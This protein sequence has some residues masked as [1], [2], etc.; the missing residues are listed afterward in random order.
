MQQCTWSISKG[1]YTWDTAFKAYHARLQYWCGLTYSHKSLYWSLSLSLSL[2]LSDYTPSTN[3]TLS[4]THTR[5]CTQS[6]CH[7]H[8]CTHTHIHLHTQTGSMHPVSWSTKSITAAYS[9]KEVIIRWQRSCLHHQFATIMDRQTF[10][11]IPQGSTRATLHMLSIASTI[12]RP[13]PLYWQIYIAAYTVSMCTS[14]CSG[15]TDDGMC[16]KYIRA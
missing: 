12:L 15:T 1:S 16:I 11:F 3:L 8:S 7:T 2:S 14:L 6:L 13:K 4:R 5:T 9:I 10:D